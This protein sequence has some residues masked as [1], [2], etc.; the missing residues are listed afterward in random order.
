VPGGERLNALFRGRR[1]RVTHPGQN[2]SIAEPRPGVP[3]GPSDYYHGLLTAPIFSGPPGGGIAASGWPRPERPQAA[4][5][6]EMATSVSWHGKILRASRDAAVS[7]KGQSEANQGLLPE[8]GLKRG[9]AGFRRRARA[10]FGNPP[11]PSS[12]AMFRFD[13]MIRSSMTVR[14]V[15]RQFPETVP[16]F[17]SFGFRDVCDD[18]S[19]EVGARRL[20]LAAVDV[21]NDLN[22]SVFGDGESAR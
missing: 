13:Q 1:R 17:A 19:I 7:R 2:Q 8:S 15:K 11:A 5:S 14:E 3:S 10:G 18:C 6:R 12:R 20:G 21:V 4:E 22:R 9:S 16:V